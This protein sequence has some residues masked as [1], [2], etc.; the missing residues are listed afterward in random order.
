LSAATGSPRPS[1]PKILLLED[2]IYLAKGLQLVLREGGYEVD[3]AATGRHALELVQRQPYDLIIADLWLPD[4]DGLEIIQE[5][6]QRHPQTKF[7]VITGY[8]T[9]ASVIAAFKLGTSDYLEKPFTEQEI[10]A[11]IA[12]VLVAP[13]AGVSSP[14]GRR[15]P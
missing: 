6:K 14:T 4:R 11:A 12:N 1:P 3:W 10:M 7:I 8:S 15:T 2:E 9:V 5:V 13:P